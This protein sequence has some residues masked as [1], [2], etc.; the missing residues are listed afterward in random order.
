M[1]FIKTVD[2]R[3]SQALIVDR[4]CLYGLWLTTNGSVR[5][6]ANATLLRKWRLRFD[7]KRASSFDHERGELFRELK[8]D[9]A[10]N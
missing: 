9:S 2:Q 6:V 10:S 3:V 5:G 7:D 4:K 8:G 1:A